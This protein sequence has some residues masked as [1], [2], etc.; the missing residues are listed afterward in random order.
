LVDPFSNFGNRIEKNIG[1]M[2]NKGVEFEINILP[3][4]KEK[5]SLRISYNIAYNDNKVSKMPFNQ[6][7]GGIEGGVGNTVQVHKEGY[8][9]YSFYVYQQVY[10]ADN[11]PIEGVYV[12]RNKDG[13]I[14][15]ED[16]YFYKDPFADIAMGLSLFWHY[17]NFDVSISNR[18]SIGNYIYDNVHQSPISHCV[19]KPM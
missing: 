2:T 13:V 3:F 14:N 10:D 9:P 1:D 17:H 16:K 18:A 6:D 4:K 11:H 5:S 7:V 15:N 12:D 19:T 8:A